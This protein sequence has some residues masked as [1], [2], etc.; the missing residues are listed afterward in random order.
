MS[1]AVNPGLALVCGRDGNVQRVMHDDLG[2]TAPDIAGTPFTRLVDTSSADKAR[3]F[4]AEAVTAGVA[5]DWELGVT[6][7]GK[8]ALLHF[9]AAADHAGVTVVACASGSV[10]QQYHQEMMRINNEQANALRSALKTIATDAPVRQH[11]DVYERMMALNNELATLQRE[12]MKKNMELERVSRLKNEFVGMAAHDLRNPLGAIRSYATLLLDADIPLTPAE[13]TSFLQ[14]IRSST[15]FMILLIDDL[16]DLTAIE[17]GGLRLRRQP[18]DLAQLLRQA[19]ELD[20]L[21][22]REKDV[23]IELDLGV[24]PIIQADAMKV[25]QILHNLIGNAV[26]FSPHDSEIAVAL[27]QADQGV[28]ISIAD[29]G[30]GI[31]DENLDELFLPFRQGAARGTAGEKSTGLGLAIVKRLV[32]GH[33]GRIA[34][35]SVPGWGATFTVWLPVT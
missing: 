5:F 14:R 15:E 31:A 21:L 35:A 25:E 1:E 10:L 32:D 24:V 9:A 3:H 28:L 8:I 30:P 26:K 33:G 4:L 2:L 27:R 18:V 22:A 7:D 16:L 19:V 23:R 6:I 34:Y 12:L 13:A 11:A 29:H 17:D 20:R